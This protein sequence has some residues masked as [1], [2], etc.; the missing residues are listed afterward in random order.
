M[1]YRWWASSWAKCPALKQRRQS[2]MP[3]HI[4][5]GPGSPGTEALAAQLN[6]AMQTHGY[7]ASMD[8]SLAF[9]SVSPSAATAA[10]S[11][12]G[13]PQSLTRTLMHQ[14]S[15]QAR[16]LQC[17][18]VPAVLVWFAKD[19]R[20]RAVQLQAR[21]GENTVVRVELFFPQPSCLPSSCHQVYNRSCNVDLQRA[22]CCPASP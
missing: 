19:Q 2:M 3:A 4:A 22:C 12:L 9:N 7:L 16:Y 20:A 21:V 18:T 10:M 13:L 6:N 11:Q 17:R 14:W 5:G 1:W 8:C 15:N